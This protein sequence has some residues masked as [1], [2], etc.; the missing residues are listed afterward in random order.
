[1]FYVTTSD[2]LLRYINADFIII[3]IAVE[4]GCGYERADLAVNKAYVL[5]P[6]V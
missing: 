4:R 5:R 6:E 1:M 2:Y 3:I